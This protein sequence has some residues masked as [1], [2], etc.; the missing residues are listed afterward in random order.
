MRARYFLPVLL[1]AASLVTGCE[2]VIDTTIT[3][4]APRYVIEGTLNNNGRCRV[5]ISTT[6]ALN[7]ANDVKGISGAAVQLSDSSGILLK[8]KDRGAGVYDS[9]VLFKGTPGRTY[10]LQVTIDGAVFTASSKMPQPV[11]FEDVTITQQVVA[12]K[13]QYVS[14][15]IYQDP[16]AVGNYYRF[17]QFVNERQYTDIFVNSD[18]LANG[19]QVH[20]SL[21]NPT[22]LETNN[23]NLIQKGDT[24]RV[25]MQ[26]IDAAVYKYWYSLNASASGSGMISTPSNPVTNITGG[27]LG[28]FSAY[29][30]QS[31]RAIVK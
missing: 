9:P 28:Y 1:I 17:V 11:V 30:S 3:D 2:K 19:R 15:A 12:G 21:L 6:T 24:V 16:E 25:E 10:R 8:L 29:S 5:L 22:T 4:A 23:A 14:N 26:C 31:K 13:T 18:N 7:A 20:Y 27:A